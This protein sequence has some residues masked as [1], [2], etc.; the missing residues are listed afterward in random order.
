M[1]ET[2]EISADDTGEEVE[3]QRV[4][5]TKC[6][7]Y[8][9]LT[10]EEAKS[11]NDS[12]FKCPLCWV[13]EGVHK[14]VKMYEQCGTCGEVMGSGPDRKCFCPEKTK[15][16]LTWYHKSEELKNPLTTRI[17]EE[18]EDGKLKTLERKVVRNARQEEFKRKVRVD[19]NL[20]E[21][22]SNIKK[23]VDVIGK[24]YVQKE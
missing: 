1:S 3:V 7:H 18:I 13:P 23:L 24:N 12:N 16:A 2:W 11:V 14:I 17:E 6:G 8:E 9:F 20:I 21:L 22:N 19:K 5:C 15:P 10:P 4:I